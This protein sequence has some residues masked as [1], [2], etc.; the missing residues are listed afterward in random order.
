MPVP[1]A[2]RPIRRVAILGPSP[3]DR[4][5]IARETRLLAEE[6]S[7]RVELG[8]RWLTFSRPYPRWLDPRRFDRD[9][10]LPASVAEPLLDYASPLSWRRTAEA[11]AAD[12]AEALLVPWWTAFWALPLRSVLR[13]VRRLSAKTS[14]VIALFEL[15]QA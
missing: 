12:G 3:P 2:S 5:G 7:R 8:V 1:D 6:L 4:G 10:A 13:R 11:V 15:Q 9:S 14:R